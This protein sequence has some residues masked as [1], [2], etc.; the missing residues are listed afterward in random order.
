MS[1]PLQFVFYFAVKPEKLWEGLFS[2][3]SNRIIF[4]RSGELEAIK[5]GRR[6]LIGRDALNEFIERA[7]RKAKVSA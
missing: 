5:L 7:P 2:P 1:T 6:V 3:E 4:V